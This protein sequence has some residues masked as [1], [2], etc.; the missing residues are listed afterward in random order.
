MINI[1]QHKKI[2]IMFLFVLGIKKFLTRHTMKVVKCLLVRVLQFRNKK[3]IEKRGHSINQFWIDIN[4]MRKRRTYI[5]SSI[6]RYIKMITLIIHTFPHELDNYAR[7]LSLLELSDDYK[8]VQIKS[9]L[10]INEKLITKANTIQNE[11]EKYKKISK[12]IT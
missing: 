9:V 2:K 6:L 12:K 7:V 10:N 11:I 1:N 4:L 8:S 3:Y 5:E